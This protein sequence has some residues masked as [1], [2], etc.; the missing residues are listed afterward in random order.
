M[1]IYIYIYLCIYLFSPAM[2][3]APATESLPLSYK[4]IKI[5]TD[6]YACISIHRYT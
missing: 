3:D 1:Y 5:Y 2:P 6:I 4:C